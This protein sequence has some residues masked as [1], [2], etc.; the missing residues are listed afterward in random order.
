M[1][2]FKKLINS[3][4]FR[5]YISLSIMFFL[6]HNLIAYGS[7]NKSY[8]PKSKQKFAELEAIYK[9]K[10]IPYVEYDKFGYQIKTFFGLY[11]TKS[12]INNYPDLSIIDTSDALRNGYL[13]KLDDMTR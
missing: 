8:I 2:L 3:E 10:S 4:T 9:L 5:N 6:L 12:E 1:A 11:S 13:I 7:D